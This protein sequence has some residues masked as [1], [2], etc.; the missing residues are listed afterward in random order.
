MVW[1]KDFFERRH[2][3][4]RAIARRGRSVDLRRAI[5]VVAQREFRTG[6]VLDGR[7]RIK[8]H[9]VTVCVAHEELADVFRVGAIIAFRFYVNLP[10]ATEPIEVI[11]EKAAHEC[12]EGLVN[13]AEI[14]PLFDH[15][16]TIDVDEDLRNVRQKRRNKGA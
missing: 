14:D 3:L 13:L 11:H 8:R 12:L 5:F 16:V 9:S 4:V 7:D 15:F 10:C 6:D 1:R 2:R